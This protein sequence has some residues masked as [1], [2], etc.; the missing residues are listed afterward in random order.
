L[1]EE[2]QKRYEACLEKQEDKENDL[3]VKDWIRRAYEMEKDGSKLNYIK[4]IQ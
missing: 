3:R 4:K 2:Y 1:E